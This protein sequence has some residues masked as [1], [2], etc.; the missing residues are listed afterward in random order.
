MR[1]RRGLNFSRR[2][3]K[4]DVTILK[5]VMTWIVE[6]V[7]AVVI[8]YV[9][10]SSFGT[11]TSVVGAAME[12]VLEEGNQLLINR[13]RYL[14]MDPKQGDVV[15]FQPNGNEKSHYYVR[16]IIGT[17]GDTV[18]IKDGQV[19]VNGKIY[20]EVEAPD[21]EDA[22]TAAEEIKLGTGEYFVLG[23]NRNNSEDSRFASIGNVK[24]E[25]IIGKAWF[26]FASFQ[27]M[28]FIH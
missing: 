1:R 23:D 16:R 12:P 27:N 22:G 10:V 5:E 15:L 4:I 13:F 3:K 19:Y 7:L 21:I 28:G 20:D 24:E 6:I 11:R 14:L 26:Y 17:P 2:K 18:L 8:A 9:C 25:Y